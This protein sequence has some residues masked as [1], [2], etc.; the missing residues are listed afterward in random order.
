[1][2]DPVTTT[3]ISGTI[4]NT[5]SQPLAGVPI[6]LGADQTLTAAD[7]TFTL[8]VTSPLDPADALFVRGEA[9]AGPAVY[10]FIAEKLPLLLGHD[11]YEHVNNVIERPIYLPAL[12]VASGST[13][14]PAVDVT[15]TTPAIP[16]ASVFVAAGS[17]DDPT[18]NPFTGVLSITEVPVDLTPAALPANLF[19]DL[20]VTIQ[21]G[22]MVFTTPAPL[23]LPNLGGFLP[24]MRLDLWSINP[25]TGLFDNVGTGQVSADGSVIETI[26]GGIRNSSW[27]FFAFGGPTP[28]NPQ[29]DPRN[30]NKNCDDDCE[31]RS[32]P[33]SNPQPANG[34]GPGGG[35]GA[36]QQPSRIES[37]WRF[38]SQHSARH[39]RSRR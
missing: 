39:L 13:I 32:S 16:G 11:G 20:V 34:S 2:A 8:T 27:H 24:G 18:G 15:V 14:D 33:N 21:P 22:E 31:D 9:I 12:D 26:S 23:A 36:V 19:P 37:R 4:L 38:E 3:R 5:D 1:M 25:Q 35:A 28:N 29:N 10:P 7:G 30:Q 17:L 6:E